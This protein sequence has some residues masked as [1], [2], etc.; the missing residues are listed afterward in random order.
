MTK[1]LI[2]AGLMF[3]MGLLGLV[4]FYLIFFIGIKLGEFM[5]YVD[6][7]YGFKGSVMVFLISLAIVSIIGAFILTFIG[8]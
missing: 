7:E 3:G 4:G 1:F 2:T 6:R 8:V 5:D